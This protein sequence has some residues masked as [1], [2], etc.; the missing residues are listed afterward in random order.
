MKDVII[1]GGGVSGCAAARELSRYQGEFL[2]IDK[3]EDVCCGTSKANSAIVHAGFDAPAGSRMAA[4]NVAGSRRMPDL[5]KE[6]DFAY[7]QCGSLVVCLSE[8]DRPALEKLLENGRANGVEGLRIVERAELRAMEPNIADEAVAALWAPT[9][10]IV[11]PFGLTYAF[12]EN[13][14]RNGVQFQFHTEVQ[15]IEPMEGGWRLFT[16]RGPL[17]T[18]CVVNAAG[19]HADELHNQVSG[20][21]MTIVP[22][23]G[24]YFLLDH[25]AGAHVHHTIFQL[26]G[27]FGKGV[28]VTPTVHGNLLVGPTATDIDDKEDTA[29]TAAELAEVRAKAGLAVKDLP[30]R[31]TITSF[32][33]LR[34]HEVRHEFFIEEAAPGFVDCAGIESPGLSASPAIGLEVARLVQNILHLA[35]NPGFDPHRKGILDPKTLPF[36]E[37]AALVREHPAYGQVICRCETVTEGEILDAIHRVPGARSLDGVKRRTRAGM[38]RCQAGFC[39]PRVLEI[40]ARELGVPQEAITKCGGDSRLIAGTNKD[41]L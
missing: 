18:R 5:A 33:G 26:P 34:A 41:S 17:E 3:E 28:L 29:T 7:Q 40:L 14:A 36:E 39:S 25:A 6:L 16:N 4:L 11:C 1:I 35:E 32:A 27:K 21:T 15:R 10:G 9:G 2:L 24:D 19:V 38:G 31:Q 23:R 8:E 22:R 37:R 12:A 20:D 30:L 13:A